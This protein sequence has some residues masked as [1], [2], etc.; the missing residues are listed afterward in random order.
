[1]IDYSLMFLHKSSEI[2]SRFF[3]N[4][5]TQKKLRKISFLYLISISESHP[6]NLPIKGILIYISFSVIQYKNMA[7]FGELVLKFQCPTSLLIS[8]SHKKTSYV[9][10]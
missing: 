4:S 10:D 7:T 6:L 5:N 2:L 9:R 1:M 8:S 3:E